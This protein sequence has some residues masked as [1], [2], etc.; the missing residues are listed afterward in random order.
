MTATWGCPSTAANAASR[1]DAYFVE[2]T[3]LRRENEELKAR[4]RWLEAQ[5]TPRFT[6][7][8]PVH[9]TGKERMVIEAL[10]Q[11]SPGVPVTKEQ[12]HAIVYDLDADEVSIKIIDL[13]ICKLRKKLFPLGV[14]IETAWGHGY[15][16]LSGDSRK[17][18]A[19]W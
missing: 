17:I 2:V 11:A 10:M 8:V 18:V 4:V 16:G 1:R 19:G 6:I 5:R 9:L 15:C 7:N 3:A 13:W 12:L 14:I